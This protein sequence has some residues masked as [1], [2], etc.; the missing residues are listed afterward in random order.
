MKKL[1]LSTVIIVCLAFGLTSCFKADHSIRVK[2][3]FSQELVG[4]TINSTNYGNIAAGATTDYKPVEEG[5]FSISGSTS[6]NLSISG[7]GSV[8][9]KGKHDWTLTVNPSGQFSIAEDK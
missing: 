3:S 1:L 7:S 5:S 6:G 2:N 4:L 8:K 9:G